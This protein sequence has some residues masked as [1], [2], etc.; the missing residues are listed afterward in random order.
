MGRGT[1][2]KEEKAGEEDDALSAGEGGVR[3]AGPRSPG[4]RREPHPLGPAPSSGADLGG[5]VTEPGGS[6][7]RR[8]RRA[9]TAARPGGARAEQAGEG[10]AP[11]AGGVA[12]RPP[13]PRPAWGVRTLLSPPLSPRGDPWRTARGHGQRCFAGRRTCV[14]SPLAAS[15]RRG[16]PPARCRSPRDRG[17]QGGSPPP[18]STGRSLPGPAPW[19]QHSPLLGWWRYAQG[20]SGEVLKH[21]QAPPFPEN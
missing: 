13:P 4:G 18:P 3:Q 21:P 20:G 14:L 7:G 1:I 19:S 17:G 10:R 12:P 8:A 11:G 6:W 2:Q 9:D 5:H 15:R 16:P